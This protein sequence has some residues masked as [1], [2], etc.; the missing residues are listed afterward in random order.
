MF[1]YLVEIKE[2]K[3]HDS[4]LYH[5]VGWVLGWL[6]PSQATKKRKKKEFL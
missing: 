4:D 5:S 3:V 6:H 2:R 1:N